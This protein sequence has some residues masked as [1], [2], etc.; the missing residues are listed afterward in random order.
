MKWITLGDLGQHFGKPGILLCLHYLSSSITELPIFT[1]NIFGFRDNPRSITSLPVSPSSS[2][3]HR[4]TPTSKSC[5]LS[6]S[7]PSYAWPGQ[8]SSYNATDHSVSP[9][10]RRAGYTLDPRIESTLFKTHTSGGSPNM[11][12]I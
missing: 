11:W 5:F 6:P 1:L 12:L 2:P 9:T 7:H 3:L 4:L 10:R 8:S